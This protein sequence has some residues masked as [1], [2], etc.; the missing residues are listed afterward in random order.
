MD[1]RYRRKCSYYW[2]KGWDKEP[3]IWKFKN[4]IVGD[5]RKVYVTIN[6]ELEI[7]PENTEKLVKL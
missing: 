7:L 2:Y 6:G 3:K 4:A 1:W 5:G